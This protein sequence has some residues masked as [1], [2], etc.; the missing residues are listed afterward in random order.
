MGEPVPNCECTH[1]FRKPREPR[2]WLDL[3]STQLPQRPEQLHKGQ[4]LPG[5]GLLNKQRPQQFQMGQVAHW[6]ILDT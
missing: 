3:L 2:L 4:L 6:S 5:R 1:L